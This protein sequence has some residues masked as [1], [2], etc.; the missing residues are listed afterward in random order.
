MSGYVGPENAIRN[1]VVGNVYNNLV[2]D[3]NELNK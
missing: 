1:A 2:R 3:H